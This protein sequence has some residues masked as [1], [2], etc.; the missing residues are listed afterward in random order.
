MFRQVIIIKAIRQAS[1]VLLLALYGAATLKV[2]SFHE[3]FHA[4]E[5]ATLHSPEQESNPCHKSVYHQQAQ[6]GCEHKSHITE[7]DKCPLCEFNFVPDQILFENQSTEVVHAR[8]NHC[9]HWVEPFVLS[10][11]F[12]QA[13]R[14]PPQ[15]V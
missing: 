3:L 15:N 1:L 7:N 11:E 9:T 12:H 6:E 8:L 2:D 4:Q 10:S 13:P 14:G 5:L